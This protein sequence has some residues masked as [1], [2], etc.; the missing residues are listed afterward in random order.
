MIDAHGLQT[1]VGSR[2]AFDCYEQA[3]DEMLRLFPVCESTAETAVNEYCNFP[4][5]HCLRAYACTAMAQ[6]RGSETLRRCLEDAKK[7]AS[8][9]ANEREKLHIAAIEQWYRGDLTGFFRA[10]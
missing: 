3:V 8:A 9:Q 1:T 10:S 5:A 4:M 6:S 2:K 7:A